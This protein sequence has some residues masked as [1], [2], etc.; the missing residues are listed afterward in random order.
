PILRTTTLMY[1]GF[2]LGGGLLYVGLPI[3]AATRLAG[4]AELYG[5]L[6]GVLGA[7]EMIG[8]IAAGAVNVSRPLGLLICLGQFLSGVALLALPLEGVNAA[9][10]G[11]S[12]ALYGLFSAPLTVWAQTLRMSIIPEHL[13]GRTFAL[14]RTLMQGTGPVGG[15]VAGLI[16]PIIGLLPLLAL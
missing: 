3:L 14:L 6:L 9:L 7:G 2:N 15:A 11:L 12:L 10:V 1:M 8:A 16:L 4:G 5:L 13:R